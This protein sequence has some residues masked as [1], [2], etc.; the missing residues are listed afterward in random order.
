[1]LPE[2]REPLRSLGS[3]SPLTAPPALAR[4]VPAALA[5]VRLALVRLALVSRRLWPQAWT[6]SGLL[7]RAPRE[8]SNRAWPGGQPAHK[9]N[10]SSLTCHLRFR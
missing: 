1:L 8:T 6:A 7:Q 9:H 3:P 10:P 2:V 4:L 5:L